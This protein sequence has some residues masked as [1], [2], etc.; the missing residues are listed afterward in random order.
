MGDETAGAEQTLQYLRRVTAELDRTRRQLREAT[1]RDL[2]PI[3]IVGMACRYP[4]G[5]AS[6]EDLWRLVVAETDAISDFPRDRGWP[7]DELYDPDQD[8]PGKTYTRH[9]GFLSDAAGFDA[10]FFGVG[11]REAAAMDPQQRMLLESAWEAIE[12]A[13]IVPGALRDGSTGV[14][15]G[16]MH[17]EYFLGAR[18]DAD[19]FGG[20]WG[21]GNAGSV[22]SGRIAYH[23]GLTGPALTVDTACSSSLVAVH[24]A[25]QSLRRGECTSA[26]AAGV[27]VMSSPS[28]FV[29][30]S[31]QGGCSESG[32]CRSFAAA[33]DGTGWAEGVGTIVLMRLADAERH[34]HQVLA[35][36]RGTA[37]NQDGASYGLTAP[38]GVAQ[39]RVIAD[40]LADARLGPADID[41]V[42][43][44]GTGTVLGDPIEAQALLD[45]FGP[46]RSAQ[47]PLYV[48]SVKSNIGHTQAAAGIAG[49]IKMVMALRHDAMP[50]SL[51]IDKPT[52]KLD[53]TSGRVALLEQT[54]PWPRTSDRP[55]RFGVS[56]F[57]I[58]GTN[59]H[60]IVEEAGAAEPL[61][62][63]PGSSEKYFSWILSAQTI[64]A[65]RDQLK[66]LHT[67]LTDDS[68]STPA[69]LARALATTR[70][71]FDQRIAVVGS[72]RQSMAD[73]VLA[74]AREVDSAAVRA[75][76][77]G[78]VAFMFTGQGA[79]YAGMGT[80]LDGPAFRVYTETL[81]QVCAAFDPYL[82]AALISALSDPDALASAGVVQP[83]LFAVEVALCRLFESW[84]VRA[85]YL[86]GH[87]L[88]EFVAAYLADVFTLDDACRVVA[89]RGRLMQS[90]STDGAM[91]S[92]QASEAE[93]RA[94]L[95]D[96][97]RI[98]VA[99]VNGPRSVVVSG[100]AES[101]AACADLW[102]TRGRRTRSLR[103][104]HAFHSH[105]VDAILEDFAA[106]VESVHLKP[107]GTPIV[108]GMT[109]RPITTAEATDPGYWVRQL[110]ATVRFH[111]GIRWLAGAGV[112][113][114][115]E[116]GPSA[117]LTS[118]VDECLLGTGDEARTVAALDREVPAAQQVVAAAAA[119]H[120]NGVPIDWDAYYEN[121][122]AG[123]CS[124][125]VYAFQ[126]TR[127]WVPE[128]PS[129]MRTS[130]ITSGDTEIRLQPAAVSAPQRWRIPA[131][132]PA[133]TLLELV[134][135]EFA[136]VLGVDEPASIDPDRSL[137]QLGI[138]SMN[139]VRL[140]KRFAALT[141]AELP[142]PF[143]ID[144]P[145][146]TAVVRALL[147]LVERTAAAGPARSAA[148]GHGVASG[149]VAGMDGASGT[150]TT[151]LS[152]AVAEGT[153]ADMIGILTAASRVRAP[154]P[155][156]GQSSDGV[157]LLAD[158]PRD[159]E[160]IC[161]PSFLAGSG[162][163]QFLRFAGA[164]SDRGRVRGLTLPGFG[165]ADPRPESWQGAIAAAASAIAGT[166]EEADRIV[167]V[168]HSMG[169][170][171]ANDIAIELES[172]GYPV[173][174]VV[175]LDTIEPDQELL[176]DTFAWAMGHI[177]R[178]DPDG[179]VI[180]DGNLLSMGTYLDLFGQWKAPDSEALS[181]ASVLLAAARTVD[182]DP[183]YTWRHWDIA[184]EV[185][186]VE[187]DHFSMLEADARVSADSVLD[188]LVR[189]R[190]RRD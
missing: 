57:G 34:G 126:H 12:H 50:R 143:L 19:R 133:P 42:E 189:Q 161:V 123:R 94:S 102:A 22:A 128:T 164:L 38:N 86:I 46:G 107:P 120:S 3:A 140:H 76:H 71:H 1:E 138:E 121:S 110:R 44:H 149:V 159:T 122:T 20:L 170:L 55:R 145:T 36:I 158:G 178:R 179:A 70:T 90:L 61:P 73:S 52:P 85:D 152:V 168:G 124:L 165:N 176:D 64:P 74:R 142:P 129:G 134:R 130:A 68:Q 60:V 109:G 27:T 181:A 155:A 101:V 45:V 169:G 5:V 115:V 80:E 150:L 66:R 87:S 2:E 43:A 72:D 32:R 88:G 33:A 77:E 9:G 182:S 53:W 116:L 54:R 67:H 83:A 144:N 31:R 23:L 174:G 93:V 69:E 141:G 154:R 119:L 111:D 131:D 21:V 11:P 14:F 56:A 91:Y 92:I 39:Q 180:D 17:Q 65:L 190:N 29:E 114:Y 82:G 58:S 25:V 81:E 98:A 18:A 163:H 100:D 175:M 97:S 135:A 172:L 171:L 104:S 117:V 16:L 106:V 113:H 125:P 99:A 147:P 105:Y 41:V 137:L 162:P 177:V 167:L 166:T 186:R 8:A 118:L 187:A 185:I 156:D 103:V 132:D 139:A 35:V 13:G 89:A 26:L 6:P 173:S 96:A 78:R 148:T 59:C 84:G 30:F 153:A 75:A 79:Q 7:V 188:W 62:E 28:V 146:A 127:F 24:L 37:V 151:L 157:V 95:A 15:V 49:L 183:D 160:I 10:G 112:T 108:S 51:H 48:G 63:T 4:G 47:C 40:A 184:D 136:R